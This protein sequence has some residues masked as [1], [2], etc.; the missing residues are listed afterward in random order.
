[1]SRKDYKIHKKKCFVRL[2][3]N[4]IGFVKTV[5]SIIMYGYYTDDWKK[6]T[7]KNCLRRKNG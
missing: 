6:V 7:C 4:G 1:M 3:C 5:C 2:G